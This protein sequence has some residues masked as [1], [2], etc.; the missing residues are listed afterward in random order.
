M[1]SQRRQVGSSFF[2]VR[3]LTLSYSSTPKTLYFWGNP[4]RRQAITI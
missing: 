1:Q 3:L 4:C 2:I